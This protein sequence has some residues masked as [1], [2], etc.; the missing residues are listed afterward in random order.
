M[1]YSLA[2]YMKLIYIAISVW[3]SVKWSAE[4]LCQCSY[5]E[6]D[7]LVL[8]TGNVWYI[9]NV[10][11][12]YLHVFY[13]GCGPDLTSVQDTHHHSDTEG[14]IILWLSFRGE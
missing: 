14:V 5:C 3:W 7:I 2:A 6:F 4:S 13:I 1:Y 11:I 8:S 12:I 9:F 10:F